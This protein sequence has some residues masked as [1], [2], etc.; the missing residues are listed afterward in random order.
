MTVTIAIRAGD[1]AKVQRQFITMNPQEISPSLFDEE[2]NPV[3]TEAEELSLKESIRKNGVQVPITVGCVSGKGK[4]RVVMGTRRH[5]FALELGL[6]EIPVEIIDYASVE[7]MRQ[8]AIRDNLERR[9][10]S[11]IAKARLANELWLS[12]ENAQDRREM[13]ANGMGPRKRAAIAG[14]L[15]EGSL[16]SFRFVI[17]SE[18]AEVIEDMMQNRLSIDAA[19]R[20][21]KKEIEGVGVVMEESAPMRTKRLIRDLDE[22]SSMK[23]NLEGLSSRI[24]TALAAISK[25]RAADRTRVI[26]KLEKARKSLEE[27][28]TSGI[29]PGLLHTLLGAPEGGYSSATTPS[30]IPES[31]SVPGNNMEGCDG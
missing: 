8:A 21:A 18:I 16:A 25:G 27:I 14:G 6:S 28:V 9:H 2:V 24:G 1:D 10:L 13:S 30:E 7:E 3:A 12:Y 5:K 26:K 19:Y 29:V 22:I 11:T 4:C 23:K 20:A 17:D 31:E 15:S